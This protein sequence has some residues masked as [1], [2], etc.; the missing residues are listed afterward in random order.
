MKLFFVLI[1][2]VCESIVRRWR[3][4]KVSSENSYVNESLKKD[5]ITVKNN[6]L[7]SEE[8]KHLRDKID[9]YISSESSNVW[10]DEIGAD[11]RIY[12]INEV[13]SDFDC[14]YKD[15]LI[16]NVLCKYT[17]TTNPSGMLLAARIDCKEG[18]LGSGGGWHRDSPITHQFKA[19]CYLSDVGV[20]NGPFQYIKG[21]HKKLS[22]LKAYLMKLFKAGQYRFTEKEIEDYLEKTNSDLMELIGHEGTLAF[23]D[24]KGIHRGKPIGEGSRYVLFCY[25]WHKSIPEHFQNLR[26]K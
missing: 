11:N 15:S 3:L 7:S 19:I 23:V 12:F 25:F 9:Y 26:Q 17:G 13:D 1:K 4:L 2:E 10:C 8:C 6:Y 22:L 14:F 18:N 21:S 24:T 16:R 20:K 5:G